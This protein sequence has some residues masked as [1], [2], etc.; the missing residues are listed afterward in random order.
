[1]SL[2]ILK[3]RVIGYAVKGGKNQ[4]SEFMPSQC[5]SGGGWGRTLPPLLYETLFVT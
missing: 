4:S 5:A 3:V 1:M 2:N